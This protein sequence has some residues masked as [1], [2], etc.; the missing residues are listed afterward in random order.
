MPIIND[1]DELDSRMVPNVRYL[2]QLVRER[3]IGYTLH[4][5]ETRR[6]LS[7]QMAYYSRGRC[8]VDVVK[9][10]FKRCGLWP[11]ND[12]E[13]KTKS[14]DTLYSKHIDGFAVD[15]YL[16]DIDKAKILYNAPSDLWNELFILAEDECGLDACA[17]RK[18]NAWGWDQA[19]FEF[20]HTI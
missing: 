7:T 5:N 9:Y 10:Y 6:E 20:V 4:V 18:M 12:T 17:A 15:L 11:I 8:P 3:M 19:H 2:S 14:T 16:Y 13:C 1:V